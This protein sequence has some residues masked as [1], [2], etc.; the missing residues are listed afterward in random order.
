MGG[1]RSVDRVWPLV[2]RKSTLDDLTSALDD[3]TSVVLRGPAGVGK[4]RILRELAERRAD[5]GDVIRMSGVD[6]TAKLPLAPLLSL[7]PPDDTGHPTHDIVRHALAEIYGRSATAPVVLVVD[8]AHRL[9]DEVASFVHQVCEQELATAVIA[10]R[11]AAGLPEALDALWRSGRAVRR[12]LTPL[13][14]D[15]VSALLE[16]IL[17]GVVEPATIV[18]LWE[19]S[20]GHPLYLRELVAGAV[21]R[22]V[23]AV[24]DHGVWTASDDLVGGPRIAELI[25]SRLDGLTTD[26]LDLLIAC[27][28]QPHIPRRV[29]ELVVDPRTIASLSA[30]GLLEEVT[31]GR[32]HELTPAHPLH[33]EVATA[34]ADPAHRRAVLGRLADAWETMPA[35]RST[36]PAI[37]AELRLGAG[38]DVKPELL[39]QAARAPGV[40]PV[41]AHELATLAASADGDQGRA[42][43]TLERATALGRQGDWS[44]AKELFERAWSAA[45]DHLRPEVARRWITASSDNEPDIRATIALIERFSDT[46]RDDPALPDML[47]RA[48][49]FSEPLDTVHPLALERLESPGLPEHLHA[50]AQLV[51]ASIQA[52]RGELT[53]SIDLAQTAADTGLLTPLD[54]T[55]AA[56]L[57]CDDLTWSG[58]IHE[59]LAAAEGL[60]HEARIDGDVD[61]EITM[62]HVYQTALLLAGRVAEAATE[63]RRTVPLVAIAREV[64]VGPSA[65][66]DFALALSMLHGAEHDARAALHDLAALPSSARYLTTSIAELAAAHVTT[67]LDDRRAHLAAAAASA[68]E[69]GCLIHLARALHEHHRL[70][71]ERTGDDIVGELVEVAEVTDGVAALWVREIVA[72]DSNDVD[73]LSTLSLEAERQGLD[74]LATESAARASHVAVATSDL[75]SAHVLARR[76]RRLADRVPGTRM[77]VTPPARVLTSSEDRTLEGAIGGSS[78]RQL[79]DQLDLSVRTVHGHLHRSYRKLGLAGRDELRE[80]MT[81]HDPTR[82]PIP[83]SA[84]H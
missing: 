7:L 42:D 50:A 12:E 52:H 55:R 36:D 32:R 64:H 41:R 46:L 83:E 4:S 74:L 61:R 79:A 8:D 54:R 30:H 38:A 82:A 68:R 84:R 18:R 24:G 1:S 28:A 73:G 57:V 9:S 21:E 44:T 29:I 77:V 13:G 69:R 22:G 40:D 11:E 62:R 81:R 10:T 39:L 37:I 71:I 14:F 49:M 80:L 19:A 31:V 63:G 23:L 15:D 3:G 48:R 6:A 25:R 58:R 16:A 70:G 59:A 2:G 34:V 56:S 75:G 78:D 26:E 60:L 51:L 5:H 35:Q 72:T 53:D 20:R 67:T 76:F 43:A 17:G 45:S 65:L 33:A 66:A 27:A 47:L